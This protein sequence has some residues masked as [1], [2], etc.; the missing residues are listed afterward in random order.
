VTGAVLAASLRGDE[1]PGRGA[2]TLKDPGS[3]RKPAELGLTR[4]LPSGYKVA[5]RRLVAYATPKVAVC[6]PVVPA[7]P[8]KVA[9]AAPFS[10]TR[11]D[12]GM[13]TMS[14]AS[15]S[16]NTYRGRAIETNGCH[17]AY[18][19]GW[20]R[21]TRRIVVERV[22]HGGNPAN[23]RSACSWQHLAGQRVQACRV[24]PFNQGGGFHGGHAA[25]LWDRHTEAAVLSAHGYPNQPRVRSMMLALIHAA[26]K[27]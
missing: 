21:R 17:W 13:F 10:R 8:L 11:R 9:I 1:R 16:L 24:P 2:E 3:A 4:R 26:T 20:T 6:P 15:C 19:L 7:G 27:P 23:P 22:T 5:C 25:Y 12:R 18:E 14:F